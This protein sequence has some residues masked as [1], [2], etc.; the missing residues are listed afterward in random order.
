MEAQS[1]DTEL[2]IE[3]VCTNLANLL[4]SKNRHY[5]NSALSPRQVFSKT[6]EVNAITARIDELITRIDNS[7]ALRKGDLVDLTGYLVLLLIA[8]NWTEFSDAA[9]T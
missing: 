4:K 1:E 8:N 2:K 7:K 9:E 5:G 6:S 3:A